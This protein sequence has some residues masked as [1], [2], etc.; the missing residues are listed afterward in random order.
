MKCQINR[1]QRE[2]ENAMLCEYCFSAHIEINNARIEKGLK[3]V[4]ITEYIEEENKSQE[5]LKC[6]ENEKEID[7]LNSINKD[8][9]ESAGHREYNLMLRIERLEKEV[10][11]LKRAL[12]GNGLAR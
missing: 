4:R 12:Q 11:E 10:K 6:I 2:T 9:R 5:C 8:L 1:C 7:D 3:W